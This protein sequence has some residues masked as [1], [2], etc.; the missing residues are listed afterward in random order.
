MAIVDYNNPKDKPPID[1]DQSK[2]PQEIKDRSDGVRHAIYGSQNKEFLA[3]IGEIVSLYA[4]EAVESAVATELRQDAVEQYNNQMIAE[5]TD[6]DVIS[7]PE[8]IESRDGEDKLSARLDR[9]FGDLNSFRPANSSILSKLEAEFKERGINAVWF[10]AVADNYVG[11]EAPT[12]NAAAINAAISY[13]ASNGFKEVYIPAGRYVL[14]ASVEMK[15]TGMRLRGAGKRNTTLSFQEGVD[16]I[17][18]T[19]ERVGTE[20]SDLQ[21]ETSLPSNPH[22]ESNWQ[23]SAA[24]K[25]SDE[26]GE[27]GATEFLIKNVN[28][29]NFYKGLQFKDFVW[30]SRFE[31]VRFNSCGYSIYQED[32]SSHTSMQIVFDHI[33][34]NHPY[35]GGLR[36]S[37]LQAEFINPN[38]GSQRETAYMMDI[39]NNSNIVFTVGNWEEAYVNGLRESAITI[40]DTANVSFVNPSF[41]DL[42]TTDGTLLSW[43]SV[44]NNATVFMPNHRIYQSGSVLLGRLYDRA[45]VTGSID[46]YKSPLW[47]LVAGE[48]GSYAQR[49]SLSKTKSVVSNRIVMTETPDDR[50]REFLFQPANRGLIREVKAIYIA[51]HASGYGELEVFQ[52]IS[53]SKIKLANIAIKNSASATKYSEV[54]L[55][56]Q[57]RKFESGSPVYVGGYGL[58]TLQVVCNYEE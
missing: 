20:V 4:K 57:I 46:V 7:A 27:V 55:T 14:G 58:G 39:S 41:K 25:F 6:K 17:V 11:N 43:I 8:L 26:A 37:N 29:S 3:Q 31:E 44:R 19:K 35:F 18:F 5:M 42:M 36:A 23:P 24:L 54:P 10:G 22:I 40:R 45:Q 50:I 30:Q 32:A 53:G 38:F 52:L 33:Y 1:Y 12:D 9:D 16:A 48:G 56:I 15:H 2:V 47:Y 13:A 21:I 34:S 49:L 51:P 28:I